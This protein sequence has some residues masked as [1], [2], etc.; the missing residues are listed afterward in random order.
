[1]IRNNKGAKEENYLNE[2]VKNTYIHIEDKRDKIGTKDKEDHH[3]KENQNYKENSGVDQRD[4]LLEDHNNPHIIHIQ[5]N[6]NT[7]DSRSKSKNNNANIQ[8]TNNEDNMNIN[9]H[10]T[11]N[12][13]DKHNYEEIEES[14]NKKASKIPDLK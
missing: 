9:T 3:N 6:L 1:M 4:N 5:R 10:N 7:P 8:N 2:E 14:N 13:H 12:D 11:M